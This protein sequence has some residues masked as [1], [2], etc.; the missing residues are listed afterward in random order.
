MSLFQDAQSFLLLIR[1]GT[2]TETGLRPT[3]EYPYNQ[4]N[5]GPPGR[6][7]AQNNSRSANF[8]TSAP[9][10][11]VDGPSPIIWSA[12]ATT[13]TWQS[14]F[15]GLS[16]NTAKHGDWQPLDRA[17]LGITQNEHSEREAKQPQQSRPGRSRASRAWPHAL[18]IRQPPSISLS[19]AAQS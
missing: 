10:F 18:E 8:R 11:P 17:R 13:P 5:L 19:L 9:Y 12:P 1:R 15:L 3:V 16:S 2:D 7:E 4:S 14:R 6:T